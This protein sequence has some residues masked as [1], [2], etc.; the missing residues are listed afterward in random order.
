MSTTTAPR[1]PTSRRIESGAMG[2]ATA[3]LQRALESAARES[4]EK[5]V[6]FVCAA[7]PAPVA[8]VD[9]VLSGCA[10]ALLWDP[11]GDEWSMVGMG[12][13]ARL[14]ASPSQ[15]DRLGRR[16]EELFAS[17]VYRAP[18]D[19]PSPRLFGG[20]AFAP[21]A[22]RDPLWEP[23]GEGF[24][25]LPEIAYAQRDGEAWL[26]LTVQIGA[27]GCLSGTEATS[28]KERRR[29]LAAFER[30]WS[31]VER[32][33]GISSS[34]LRAAR[35]TSLV[36]L[37]VGHTSSTEGS[38]AAE[39]ASHDGRPRIDHLGKA[40]WEQQVR[41][42]REQIK[43]G[44]CRKVVAARRSKVA[45]DSEIDVRL[46]L[47]RLGHRFDECT[48]FALWSSAEADRSVFFGAT[49][50]RLIR[51]VGSSVE[52][53]ALAGSSAR[54]RGHA[55][56]ESAK[57]RR[58]HQVV[59][60]GIERSLA[61]FCADLRSS[62]QPSLCDLPD[63]VHMRTSILGTLRASA[64][65]L[66]LVRALHP[67]AAVGGAPTSEAVRWIAEHEPAPRGWYSAPFGW[68]DASGDGDF[69]AALRSGV[70]RGSTAFV[71]AG[72]GIMEDSNAASEYHET[73]LKMH[74]VLD[75]LTS[76]AATT[77]AP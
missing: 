76:A 17:M 16:S 66:E 57:D 6:R 11:P 15:L 53:E 12:S 44:A 21:A 60:D 40:A 52:T 69:V 45:F 56:L 74:A 33:R 27:W 8:P 4:R 30:V 3:R 26:S 73:E 58:E 51:R 49:P 31:A 70:V 24:F 48:R 65:V 23:F 25:I 72:A 39:G 61:P 19:A 47:E 41:A 9:A 77:R 32:A 1:R 22:T 62:L 14:D 38:C 75:A 35:P 28:S 20:F 71:Y 34:R 55:L 36:S 29:A 2:Q 59:V 43:Q 42:I 50:E 13:A 46:V 68:F 7:V 10:P 67:T 54:A 5:P 63:V 18:A 37:P 64:H